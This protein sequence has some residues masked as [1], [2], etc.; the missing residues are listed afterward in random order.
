MLETKFRIYFVLTSW[1]QRL[2]SEKEDSIPET[3]I[4]FWKRSVY[5]AKT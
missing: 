5:L 4:Q 3:K 1:K 2:D